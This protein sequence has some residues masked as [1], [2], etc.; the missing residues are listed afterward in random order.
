M[1]VGSIGGPA[2]DG[3]GG[4][5]ETNGMILCITTRDCLL[6]AEGS[7]RLHGPQSASDRESCA[8]KDDEERFDIRTDGWIGRGGVIGGRI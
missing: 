4:D 1:C 7:L 5:Y 2:G 8:E 3:A 6:C